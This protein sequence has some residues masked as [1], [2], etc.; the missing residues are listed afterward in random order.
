MDEGKQNLE[1]QAALWLRGGANVA[2]V[3]FGDGARD[4]QAEAGAAAGVAGVVGA[5]SVEPLE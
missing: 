2:V 5:E 3:G 1:E 4:R